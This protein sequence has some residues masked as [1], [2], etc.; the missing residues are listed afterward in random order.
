MTEANYKAFITFSL[1]V[2]VTAVVVMFPEIVAAQDSRDAPTDTEFMDTVQEWTLFI[3]NTVRYPLIFFALVLAG[4]G[5]SIGRG[6]GFTASAG[7]I[8]GL[9]FFGEPIAEWV[10]EQSG[11]G[12]NP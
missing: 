3:W 7:V 1:A 10:A 9:V 11:D 2:L 12:S 8:A 4:Y 5:W 6:W